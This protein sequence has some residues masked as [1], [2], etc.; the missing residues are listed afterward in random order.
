MYIS[1]TESQ[2]LSSNVG[3]LVVSLF[4]ALHMLSELLPWDNSEGADPFGSTRQT[5]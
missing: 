4:S 1:M 5:A 2:G 3:Q